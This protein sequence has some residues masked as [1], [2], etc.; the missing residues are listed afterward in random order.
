MSASLSISRLS[1]TYQ[2][3]GI[4]PNDPLFANLDLRVEEGE[5]VLILAPFDK[6]KTTLAKIICGVCPKY[7]PGT[8]EG[9]IALFGKDLSELQSWQ[10]LTE[11]G[12]VSQNPAEQF[13]ATTVEGEI[14]FPLESLGLSREEMKTRIDRCLARWGLTELRGANEEEL[15]GGERKRVLLAIQEAIGPKLWLLD[16]PFDDLDPR[17]R[18]QLRQTLIEKGKTV[19]VFASRY[20][21]EFA[22][23]FDR[24]LLL[25]ERRIIEMEREALLARFAHVGGDDLPNPMKTQQLSL[26]SSHQLQASNVVVERQRHRGT[27]HQPFV[28]DVENFTLNS[29]EVVT[30]TGPNGSGKSSFSRLLCGLDEAKGGAVFL[31]DKEMSERQLN[32]NIGYLFQNPDFQIFL[33]TV[34]EELSWSLRR[35]R[36]IKSSEVT[37]RVKEAAE[38]FDLVLEDTPSTMSYPKRKALQA[39]VYYLLDRPFYILDE[40]D[41]ALTYHAALTII[42][43]LRE[44]GAGIL[45]ITHDHVFAKHVEGRA[46]TIEAGRLVQR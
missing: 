32:R 28:L 19:V 8:L 43:R 18:T 1:F 6:G 23:L 11:C 25:D 9:K 4:R 41:S 38:L 10:L 7:F 39:A 14:A 37:R 35:R 21:A 22:D 20:L 31:D 3:W 26:A 30:L 46:Y 27:A 36:E 13:I 40:L 16:E 44:R 34:E 12:Y 45:L 17:W 33:P 24:T 42:A 15:S 29:G 5:R 2:S